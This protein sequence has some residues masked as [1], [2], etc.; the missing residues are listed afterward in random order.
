MTLTELDARLARLE[1][2]KRT[3]AASTARS[4]QEFLTHGWS[5]D[6]VYS[7]SAHAAKHAL[8]ALALAEARRLLAARVDYP[9]ERALRYAVMLMSDRLSVEASSNAWAI[10]EHIASLQALLPTPPPEDQP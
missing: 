9:T 5:E 2:E 8:D 3:G 7:T 10:S 6:V 4:A 1:M